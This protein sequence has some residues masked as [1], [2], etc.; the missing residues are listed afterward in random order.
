M[1]TPHNHTTATTAASTASQSVTESVSQ[2]AAHNPHDASVEVSRDLEQSAEPGGVPSYLPWQAGEGRSRRRA[3]QDRAHP[4]NPTGPVGEETDTKDA[5]RRRQLA[6]AGRL[7]VR[8]RWL[9]RMLLEHRVLTSDQ[10]TQLAFGSQ[11]MATHRLGTLHQLGLLDR[12]R[13]F[14]VRGSAPLHHILA[15]AGAEFLAASYGIA[16]A[17]LGYRPERLASLVASLQL[18]HDVGA[19][20]IF[21]TL[22]A[23]ARIHSGTRL[24]AWWSE[25]RCL[26]A[27]QGGIRPDGYGRWAT[28]TSAQVRE[29]DFFLEYDTGSENLRRVVGK[30]GAYATL[31]ADSG[32]TSLVLF[33][34]PTAERE[35]NLRRLIARWQRANPSSA[36]L[37]PI[38]TA[39]PRGR[40]GSHPTGRAVPSGGEGA[41][42][43]GQ[44]D[45]AAR[46]K[47]PAGTAAD[48]VWLP[49]RPATSTGQADPAQPWSRRTLTDLYDLLHDSPPPAAGLLTT[50][51]RDLGHDVEWVGEG[52]D[53]DALDSSGDLDL[54]LDLDV[55]M[56][57]SVAPDPCPPFLA[58]EATSVT[59]VGDLGGIAFGRPA[60]GRQ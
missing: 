39:A 20:S 40:A 12:F 22:V 49:L 51:A 34:L 26:D 48:A 1:T 56:D 11:R 58:A 53:G 50:S 13:P 36:A 31:A 15:P 41:T 32:L 25:R 33:W 52:E 60:A 47:P 42:V 35:A 3:R 5:R 46:A 28:R 44:P 55:S 21:T 14:T 24:S 19:N 45:A 59:G 57:I 27:W 9:L 4:T 7:T 38:A 54:D 16:T 37:V 23:H 43:A 10:I 8:D 2:A 17:D 18:A 6:L 29:V 30:L